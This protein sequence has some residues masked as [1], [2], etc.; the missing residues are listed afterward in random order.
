MT[1]GQ[2]YRVAVWGAGVLGGA[3]I[4]EALRLDSLELVGVLA[5][6]SEKIGADVGTVLGIEPVGVTVVGDLGALVATAPDV[7][8]YTAADMFGTNVDD[9]VGLLEAGTNVITAL[10]YRRYAGR[11]DDFPE[12]MAEAALRGNA[13][14][15]VA[16]V[17]PD[18]MWDRLVGSVSGLC[19][20]IDRITVTEIFRA[21]T[22]GGMMFDAIGFG[23]P[24]DADLDEFVL[25]YASRYFEAELHVF[26]AHLG[27]AVTKTEGHCSRDAAPVGFTA[28]GHDIDAG[29]LARVTLHWTAYTDGGP[30]LAFDGIYYCGEAMRPEQAVAD[31]CWL[32]EIEGRPSI[33]LTMDTSASLD[34]SS[35][36]EGDPT[37]PGYYAT[38]N[39]ML[40]HIPFVVAAEPGY[41]AGET[42][43][44]VHRPDLRR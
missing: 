10:P 16:G 41:F 17:N 36:Y 6:S 2:P 5:Y 44:L 20:S 9:I 38:G 13:T 34:G 39:A 25:E 8:L 1:E 29:T 30:T 15:A 18:F 12:Q 23:Q 3:L 43:R 40:G 21:D 32:L 33:R 7:V 28:S 24:V 27:V 14:F 42:H 35:R 37:P 22:V 19:S 31:E 11:Q 26:A 4:R